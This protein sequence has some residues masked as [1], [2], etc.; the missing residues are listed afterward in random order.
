MRQT[1]Q[2]EKKSLYLVYTQQT[3]LLWC[4]FACI[5]VCSCFEST[6]ILFFHIHLSKLIRHEMAW[7]SLSTRDC[8]KIMNFLFW[9]KR[10]CKCTKFCLL[11]VHIAYFKH[12]LTT[13]KRTA[14]L[15]GCYHSWFMFL[16]RYMSKYVEHNYILWY[17]YSYGV[18]K[19]IRLFHWKNSNVDYAQRECF[20]PGFH[21]IIR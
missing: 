19:P 3:L 4:I 5:S 15:H 20:F 7:T 8:A 10:C 21:F 11:F 16:H 14:V 6:L 2:G 12:C 13:F 17:R 1:V 9:H 18:L